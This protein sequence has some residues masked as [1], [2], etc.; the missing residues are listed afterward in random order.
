MA[1]QHLALGW[2]RDLPDYRNLFYSVP[3]AK[4]KAR[5]PKSICVNVTNAA[6]VPIVFRNDQGHGTSGLFTRPR[7]GFKLRHLLLMPRKEAP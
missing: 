4:L 6:F 5:P 1:K 2:K 7:S 3:L